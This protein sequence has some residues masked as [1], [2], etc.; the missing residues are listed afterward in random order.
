MFNPSQFIRP[1]TSR[2]VDVGC[3]SSGR[4]VIERMT[5][6]DVVNVVIVRQDGMSLYLSLRC[7]IRNLMLLGVP[8]LPRSNQKNIQY[9]F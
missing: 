2:Y 5:E 4:I 3:S 7:Y 8:R 9:H 1:P 6:Y